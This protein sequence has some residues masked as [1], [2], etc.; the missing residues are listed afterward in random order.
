MHFRQAVEELV[1]GPDDSLIFREGRIEGGYAFWLVV[2]EDGMSLG[3]AVCTASEQ[4]K[5]EENNPTLW[6]G[7][8]YAMSTNR[9]FLAAMRHTMDCRL[10][11]LLACLLAPAT[12]VSQAKGFTRA[13]TLRGSITEARAWWDVVHY[14]IHVEP[15]YLSRYIQGRVDLTFRVLT[16]EQRMQID[17][18]EPMRIDRVL[19]DGHELPFSR[20]GNVWHLLWPEAPAQGTLQRLSIFYAGQPRVAR[21]PPWDC[22]WIFTKDTKGR[23]WMSV[24]CQGLG[25]S[26]WYPCKDHQ[27]DEPDSASLSITIPDTLTA[28]ANGRLRWRHPE[29]GGRVTYQWAVTNPINNYNIIPYIGKYVSWNEVY[30]GEAGPLDCS[31]YVLETDIDSAK[32]QFSQVPGMLRC[33]EHWFGPYPFYADGY[34]LVQ[35][36]H[37]GMEHQSAVAYGNGFRN[38]YRGTDLS[39]TGW[40]LKWDF[41]LVHESGHE[42][43]GNNIS[44]KD[45]ADMWVHE[46][47]TNY[48]ETLFTQCLSGPQAGSAYVAGTRKLI[49]NDIPI[50][51]KYGVH[52]EGSGDMYYKGGNM[53]HYMRQLFRDDERFRRALRAMN[54]TFR[55][56]TVTYAAVVGFWSRQ[57]GRDLSKL[58]QQYLTTT[59]I[60]V[61][62][63]RIQGRQLIYQWQQCLPGYNIPVAV[64]LDNQ[65]K[66]WLNPT[67]TEQRLT[68][69]RGVRKLDI[70]PDC[71]VLARQR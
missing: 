27:S 64:V 16:T 24:A 39:G 10:L 7:Q 41:I 51:G 14:A 1:G 69:E 67:T 35:S 63:W 22:G 37:L 36:P 23:P 58:F 19:W 53:I 26:S 46:S 47:F 70:H 59:Q 52:D 33:F 20:E 25:A 9:L 18:Q 31:Y 48:S 66:R 13:D 60:P 28:V 44:S 42:W 45:I 5:G 15:D 61:L 21:R 3:V 2:A 34:K 65:Q 11:A 54:D 32:A 57:C 71:Y 49:R 56:Q 68:I 4:P 38:G 12:C 50:V 17:L 6:H 8:K 43:F 30:A 40:G 29:T 62:S 55:H